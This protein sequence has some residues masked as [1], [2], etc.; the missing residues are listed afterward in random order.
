M[1]TNIEKLC[2]EINA[3]VEEDP[4]F[5]Q[6]AISDKPG[7]ERIYLDF[8]MEPIVTGYIDF[9]KYSALRPERRPRY[10]R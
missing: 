3:M 6:G 10:N 7:E 4:R 2:E 1:P 8:C 9:G 5:F